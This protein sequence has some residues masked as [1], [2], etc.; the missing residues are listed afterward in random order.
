M[1]II[2]IDPP[3]VSL[4]N[5]PMDRGYNMGLASL[6]AYLREAGLETAVIMGDLITEIRTGFLSSLIPG[7]GGSMKRYAAGQDDYERIVQDTSQPVWQKLKQMI[8]EYRPAA[9]GI[10]Y[11][12]PLRHS[13]A[14]VARLV[15]ET[16]PS[17]QVIAGGFQPTFCPDDVMSNPDIDFAVRGEGEI[18]LLALV[19]EMKKPSPDVSTLRG[20]HYRDDTG[21]VCE[22][23]P[24]DIISDLDSLPFPARDL[25]VNCDFNIY[26]LHNVI[27]ARG[28]PYTCSFCADR[29]LWGNHVRRRSVGNV[30]KEME[31]LKSTYKISYIDLV[32]GTFTYN[33]AYTQ[34]FCNE[35]IERNLNIKWRC[36]ARYDNLDPDILALMKK[37]GC[38]GM[39]FGL[40]SGSDSVLDSIDKKFTVEDIIRVSQMV[41]ESG[42]PCSTSILFGLPEESPADALATL[43]LMKKV[44]TDIFDVNSFIPLPGTAVWDTMSAEDQAGIDWLKVGYKSFNNYFSSTMSKEEFNDYLN[45]AYRIA[46]A[47]RRKTILRFALKRLIGK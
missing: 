35:L 22:T 33:R 19:R 4:K 47:T 39:Y 3:Y 46:E 1:D 43:K 45:E 29:R 21:A 20:I 2:L 15:K 24:A 36:T 34:E 28:C 31:L 14:M 25:V 23:P 40:E 16:D 7:N 9:V 44:K 5:I 12:T 27:S 10:S 18:P 6:A 41:R 30:I 13:V 8:R 26:Q 38:S 37:S 11:I 17:I 32:D 42:I